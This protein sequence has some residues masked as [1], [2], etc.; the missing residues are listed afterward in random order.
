MKKYY[1]LTPGPTPVPHRVAIKS[2]EPILHH[3]TKE[4][5][6]V[7]ASV[8]EGLKYVFRTKS[9]ILII[10]GSGTAAMDAAVANLFSPGDHVLVG[11][12]GSFGERWVKI[13]EAYGLHVEAVREDWGK[14]VDPS[15]IE[16]ALKK[17]PSIKGV[18]VQ[19]TETSAGSVNDV[20]TLGKIVA[21]TPAV[22]VV[23]AVS[24][25]AGEE[26]HMD[27]WKLDVVVSGSQKGLMTAPGLAMASLS[28]K[29]WKLV[30][31]SKCPRFYSDFRRI[32]KSI[33]DNE[34]PWTPPVSLFQSLNEAL[35]M[36]KEQTIE[37]VWERHRRLARMVRAGVQ[38]MGFPLFS[39]Q[40]CSVLTSAALPEGFDGNLLIRKMLTD[41]GVSIAGGQDHLKGKIF[42]LAHMGY[43]DSF[44]MVVG[45][46]AL[47]KTL[48]DMGYKI[49]RPGAAIKE[50][51]AALVG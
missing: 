10:P 37:G 41:H 36:I 14:P 47:E 42:R 38:A 24:G 16:S 11:S 26:L 30:E 34:T 40:P 31:T 7:F 29:A 44:D 4:F 23:D 19:H 46:T 48:I 39:S 49:S 18:L 9:D 25:L 51:E 12:V 50:A 15:K 21:S 20:K 43:M 45:L 22:L 35:K 1:L 8:Q 13:C 3:R 33:K 6:E 2:A 32:R 17:D 28:E 27:D 5:G